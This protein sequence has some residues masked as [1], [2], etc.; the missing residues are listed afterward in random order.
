MARLVSHMTEGIAVLTAGSG[1]VL[2]VAGLATR[3]WA[4]AEGG[5]LLTVLGLGGLALLAIRRW[6]YTTAR[7]A[8]TRFAAIE[9]EHAAL[10]TLKSRLDEERAEFERIRVNEPRI[11]ELRVARLLRAYERQLNTYVNRIAE[12]EGKNSALQRDYDDLAADY[13]LLIEQELQLRNQRFGRP[14][15][16]A[17]EPS[18]IQDSDSRVVRP[19]RWSQQVPAVGGTPP[20]N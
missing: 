13:N 1:A 6:G 4:P 16:V 18:Q 12:L 11:A 19:E 7:W 8:I 17:P 5:T 3:D 2:F 9:A 20:L 14:A 15:A 10:I